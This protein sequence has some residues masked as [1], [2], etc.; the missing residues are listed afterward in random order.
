MYLEPMEKYKKESKVFNNYITHSPSLLIS[1][2]VRV[3]TI[4]HLYTY[5]FGMQLFI[6]YKIN[7]L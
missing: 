2:C 3:F 4:T 5:N 7:I 1:C 6:F